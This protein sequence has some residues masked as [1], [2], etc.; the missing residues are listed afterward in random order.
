MYFIISMTHV[1]FYAD[2]ADFHRM[3]FQKKEGMYV[4][5]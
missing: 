1:D 2:K 4:L 3:L 5:H